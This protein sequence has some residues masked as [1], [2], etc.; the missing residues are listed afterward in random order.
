MYPVVPS[1]IS[2][3][4]RKLSSLFSPYGKVLFAYPQGGRYFICKVFFTDETYCEACLGIEVVLMFREDPVLY[5]EHI[6]ID[7]KYQNKGL[8]TKVLCALEAVGVEYGLYAVCVK[9]AYELRMGRLCSRLGYV[10]VNGGKFS[11]NGDRVSDFVKVL[12]KPVREVPNAARDSLDEA[13]RNM[14]FDV[15]CIEKSLDVAED[16]RLVKYAISR[17]SFIY[18]VVTTTPEKFE[19][20]RKKDGTLDFRYDE[21]AVV[22]PSLPGIP[23]TWHTFLCVADYL[24]FSEQLS[25]MGI[26]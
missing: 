18:A 6:H 4:N 15:S 16:L 10:S 20:L 7:P 2:S 17:N 26:N 23:F 5:L 19:I 1:L 11:V 13:Q 25:I 3:L 12:S 24:N 14:G 22:H 8:C 21:V 9:T